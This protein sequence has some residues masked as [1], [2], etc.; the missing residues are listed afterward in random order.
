MPSTM[1]SGAARDTRPRRGCRDRHRAPRPGERGTTKG[2]D[3]SD[4]Q[5]LRRV[6]LKISGRV[7]GV[8]YRATTQDEAQAR[9]LTGWV[10]NTPDGRV[11][12]EVQG[13]PDAV[14]DLIEECRAGPPMAKVEDIEVADLEPEPDEQRFQVV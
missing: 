13:A 9:G 12:A 8:F 3:V 4:T 2:D 10:R 11:E 6:H 7:Q 5:Q 1:T 14:D